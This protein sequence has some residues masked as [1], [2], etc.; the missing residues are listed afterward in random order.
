MIITGLIL[1]NYF[2]L[3]RQFRIQIIWNIIKGRA[4]SYN[5]MGRMHAVSGELQKRSRLE[6]LTF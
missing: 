3:T 4:D 1:D 6:L 5:A 2:A